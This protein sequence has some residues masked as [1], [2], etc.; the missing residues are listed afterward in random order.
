MKNKENCSPAYKRVMRRIGSIFLLFSLLPVAG[1]AQNRQGTATAVKAR[2]GE[3][4]VKPLPAVWKEEYDKGN[5]HPGDHTQHM[6]DLTYCESDPDRIYMGQDVCNIWVSR[7]YGKNWFTLSN[8]G[9]YS[10]FIISVEVDPLDKNRL[11]AAAQCRYYDGVNQDYQGIYQSLDGGITWS[12][13]ISRTD[14]GEVRSSTKLITYAPASKDAKLGYAKRWYA[15]FGEYKNTAKG[16]ELVADDGLLY[17]DN[18][19]DTWKEIRKLPATDFGDKIRGIK[20]DIVDQQKVF[21]YGNKGLFRFEN[22][23]DANGK[24]TKI[25]GRGGLPQG[26]IWGRLFQSKDGNTLIVAV[27][28]KGIYKS[29]DAGS[30]WSVLYTW[31]DVNYCYISENFPDKIFAVPTERSHKQIRVSSD[32]GKTWV[33]PTDD[34]IHYRP[35]Y[36]TSNWVKKLNGQFTCIIPDPRNKNN[37]FIHTKSRNFRSSDGGLNWTVSDN[38]FN[39]ASHTGIANEQMFDAANPNRFC[40]FMVDKGVIFTNTKGK[41]F[42]QNKQDPQ[43]L[44]LS[45]KTSLA[46]ALHSKKP[47]IL[48][49]VGKSPKGKLLR[50][51][52]DG[53]TWNVVSEKETERWVIAFDLDSSNYCYQGRERSDDEGVTWKELTNM[54]AKAIICGVSRSDGRVIYAMD[55]TGSRKQIWRSVNR[56]DT[57]QLVIDAGWDLTFPGPNEMFVFR[58]DPKTS[59]IVYTSSGNGHISRWDLSKMPAKHTELRVGGVNEDNFFINRFAIDPRYPDIMYA[60]NL[61]ANTGNKFFRTIDGGKTW[62]N[63]STFVP[64]GSVNGLAVSPVT[65]E[66]YI[67]SQNGSLV[68]LPPYPTSNTAYEEVPYTNNHLGEPYD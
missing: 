59:H 15:A 32:G 25:S 56:G 68:M 51:P 55:N 2:L 1:S 67:S 4:Q 53:A 37:V 28:G 58:V 50:S 23:T 43:K 33:E 39:G 7:D 24:I 29:T 41:W 30:N 13:K 65:G 44:G 57:W 16:S 3:P 45:W 9:L 34:N 60:V 38:G 11:L 12:K 46:G 5:V 66:V 63:I 31:T 54:P 35:G 42:Y 17:S 36:G 61:R 18:G 64:Q 27:S 40:Y 10:P 8:S 26:D 6:L 47:I 19:G 14:L 48:A 62:Q 20:V 49:S 52:D 22:V 21:L